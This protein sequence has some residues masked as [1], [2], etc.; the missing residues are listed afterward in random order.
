MVSAIRPAVQRGVATLAALLFLSGSTVGGLALGAILA[1]LSAGVQ[2]ILGDVGR[3]SAAV[4]ALLLAT[5]LPVPLFYRQVDR[6]RQRHLLRAYLRWGFELG[7]GLATTP[8]SR[9]LFV[10]FGLAIASGSWAVSVATGVVF[11]AVRGTI[12]VW[13]WLAPT[14]EPVLG[15]VS[16]VT[17]LGQSHR[18]AHMAGHLLARSLVVASLIWILL[19][20]A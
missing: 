8:A 7:I 17:A 12:T 13:L 5:V 4:G 18:V 11:G 14:D 15:L 9:M 19:P 2:S 3:M 1:G 10:L 16:R 6:R 20:R